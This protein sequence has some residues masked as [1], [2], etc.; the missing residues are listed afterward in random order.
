M[1][2]DLK[3]FNPMKL[4]EKYSVKPVGSNYSSFWLN[5]DWDTTSSWDEDDKPKGPDLIQLASYRRAIANFVNIVTSKNIPVTFNATGDSFTDGKKVTISAKLD[6]GLFDSAVGLALHEGSHILL[7][8]FDFLKDLENSIPTEYFNRGYKK[9]YSRTDIKVHIKNLLNYVE[10]RRIDYYVFSNSPGYKGY[11]HSMYDKYFHSKIVDKA[12]GTDEYTEENLDSYMFRIINLTNSNTRLDKLNGL[13][14]VWKVLDLKN[15]SRLSSTESAFE[16][17]LNIYNVVLNNVPDGTKKTDEN[18]DVSYERADGSGDSAHSDSDMDG[19]GSS[20]NE[21]R[22]ISDNEFEELLD[23]IENGVDGGNG[24]GGESIDLDLDSDGDSSS[25]STDGGSGS[26][27]NE[28]TEN[29]PVSEQSKVL[30]SDSQKKTLENAIKKQKKFMDDD[31]Q[32][33]KLSKKDK[34]AI[35]AID[36][37]GMSYK[38]VGKDLKDRWDGSISKKTKCVLVKNYN[39]TLVD[40]GTIDMVS[41]HNYYGDDTELAVKEGLRLGTVLG[42]KLSVR[43]ETRDTKYTRKDAGR[44]DKRLIAELGFGNSNVFSQ[45]F[46]D[47]FP[48]AFLHISVDASGSMGGSKWTRTMTS[49]VAMTKAIDMIE[50]VDVVVSFRSTQHATSGRGRQDNPI[51]L[52]AYDSRKDSLIKVKTLFKYL[53][54]NG[55]TPEGLCYEAIMDEMV[56]GMENRE[57]YFLNFSDGMPMFGNEDVAY[58]HNTALNHTKKM[59]KEIRNRGIKVVSYYIGDSYDTNRNMGEFKTMYGKDSEFVDVTSVTAVSRTMNKKFLEKN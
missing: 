56:E 36:A 14:E 41:K 54:P 24:N 12:L 9:G 53:R 35:D 51:M 45:T 19:S 22:E 44:I 32:K 8:D 7:S 46:V 28:E 15:I 23:S 39:Q 26:S 25:S 34:S 52:I 13:R 2:K 43:T 48:D 55:T 11:Y 57:S 50:G 17:A 21:P 30:L 33:K 38:E 59:V 5:N 20:S 37:S 31:V 10:D 42:R 18:G 27:S 6:D 4:R 16:T 49:V 58:H 40:S 1:N 29:V 47:S 3:Y